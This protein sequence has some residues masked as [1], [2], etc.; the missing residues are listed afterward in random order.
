[1]YLLLLLALMAHVYHAFAAIPAEWRSRSIY[2]VVTDRFARE[3]GSTTT[4][5]DPGLGEY[6]GGIFLREG[7]YK[8]D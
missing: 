4:P 7:Y 3:D 1:M 8:Q 5:C 2:Q 6:C